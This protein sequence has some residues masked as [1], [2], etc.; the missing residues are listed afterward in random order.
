MYTQHSRGNRASSS[1]FRKSFKGSSSSSFGGGPRRSSGGGFS[2]GG[3]S[4][5]GRGRRTSTFDISRYINKVVAP[6]VEDIF[7]PKHT[8]ADFGLAPSIVAT[9]A[10]TH[11]SVPTPIQD[12][13]I[14]LILQKKDVIGLANT[15]TGKTAA[16]LL[17]LIH[18]TLTDRH[19]QTL[20]LAP[21]R[22]LALQIEKELSVLARG[23]KLFAVCL[24][25]G[26]SIGAQI[27]A[28]RQFNHFIIGTPGRVQD[29]I[30]R[31]SL[32]L[33]GIR[34]VVLDEADRMLDMGF[35]NPIRMI[36][37]EVPK[38]HHTLFLSATMS[39]EIKNLV[40]EFLKTPETVSVVKQSTAAGI[41]QDVVRYGTREK[42]DVLVELLKQKG[43]DRVL[44]F[45]ETKHGVER[46]SKTLGKHGIRATSIHGNKSH[47]QRQKALKNFK[48]GSSTVLVATDVAARGIHVDKVTHVINYDL[49]MT[50]EDYI[51]RIGRTG[52]G[53]H[54]GKALTFVR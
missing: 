51:H 38:E 30:N 1:G 37:K 49:P 21:T 6:E 47:P 44:V 31:K 26:A 33:G 32:K 17:P 36:L 4:G 22:E 14:P 53:V 48:D 29:L 12:Q 41:E 18:Q 54:K 19:M 10:S 2:R 43:F 3:R 52:R 28:L 27:G 16:F 40:H 9:L 42:V 24:V 15:G 5:G 34:A 46:L 45:G 39:P 20:I 7:T 50:H 13:I 35:I 8:F 11:M 25:G 23:T